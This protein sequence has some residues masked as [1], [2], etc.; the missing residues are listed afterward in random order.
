METRPRIGL[1]FL[2]AR[3]LDGPTN[4]PALCTVSA[5][6]QGVVYYR[7][8]DE[9]KASEYV[10]LEGWPTVCKALPQEGAGCD[11]SA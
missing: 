3:I 9:R 4:Q 11:A 6:R 10:P 5:I 8:G 2:H 7:V 1:R